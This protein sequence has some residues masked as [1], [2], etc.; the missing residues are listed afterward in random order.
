M[1]VSLGLDPELELAV[2]AAV[3]VAPKTL[4][5]WLLALLES[6]QLLVALAVLLL[7]G[8]GRPGLKSRLWA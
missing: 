8:R 7:A 3:A 5:A 6:L 1:P 2:A 4:S